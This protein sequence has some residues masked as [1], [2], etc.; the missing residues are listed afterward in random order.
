MVKIATNACVVEHPF[1]A[2]NC[3][4]SSSL[5]V[6][7]K[8]KDPSTFESVEFKDVGQSLIQF[9]VVDWSFG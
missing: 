6:F 7:G 3:C 8:F 9:S 4:L 1:I 5:I 2:P